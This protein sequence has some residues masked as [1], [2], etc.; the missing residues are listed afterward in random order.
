MAREVYATIGSGTI[1]FTRG[2]LSSSQR[3]VEPNGEGHRGGTQVLIANPEDLN[4]VDAMAI[5]NVTVGTSAT[6]IVGPND[7][8]LP[9]NRT[10]RIANEGADDVFIGQ[11]DS[12]TTSTGY[13]IAA[14]S[15]ITLPLLHNVEV[16]GIAAAN[17]DIRV[18]VY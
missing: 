11:N 6:L 1:P 15:E 7:N 13:P 9:R 16:W 5:R 14:G 18:L 12:V 3:G 10:V 17:R 4:S 8:P 2:I